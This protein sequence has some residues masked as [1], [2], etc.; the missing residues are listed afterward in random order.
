MICKAMG[1]NQNNN[2]NDY[3]VMMRMNM[4]LCGYNEENGGSGNADNSDGTHICYIIKHFT[5]F[6]YRQGMI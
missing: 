6:M 4:I 1:R 3:E 2:A 5:L